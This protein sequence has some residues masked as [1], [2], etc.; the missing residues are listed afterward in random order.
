MMKHEVA[1]VKKY[2]C[3]VKMQTVLLL[4]ANGTYIEA[5]GTYFE[6][7]GTYGTFCK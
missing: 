3:A 1:E 7:N 5:N 4:E 6:A 2:A